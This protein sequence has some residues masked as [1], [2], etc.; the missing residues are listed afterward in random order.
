MQPLGSGFCQPVGQQ[1]SH[2]L[3]IGIIVEV[4][5]HTFVDTGGKDSQT[6]SNR[7]LSLGSDEVGQTETGR[8]RLLTQAGYSVSTGQNDVVAL[9]P[10]VSDEQQGMCAIG[11]CQ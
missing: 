8:A 3:L 11:S 6:G 1:L 5:L 7:L 2:H 4:R 9:S 10:R